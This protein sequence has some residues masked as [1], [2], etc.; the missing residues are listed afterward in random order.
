MTEYDLLILIAF[1]LMPAWTV[2]QLGTVAIGALLL[3]AIL[4]FPSILVLA[5]AC[6]FVLWAIWGLARTIRGDEGT[7]E[8]RRLRR[9]A[10]ILLRKPNRKSPVEACSSPLS[11][12]TNEERA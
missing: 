12:L 8:E 1:S 2:G 4:L 7:R 11:P 10:R 5:P 3:V 6:A 9:A